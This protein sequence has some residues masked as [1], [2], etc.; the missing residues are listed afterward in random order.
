MT[1]DSAAL[2]AKLD[3]IEERLD[4]LTAR[5]TDDDVATLAAADA[6]LRTGRTRRFA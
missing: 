6:D 1:A 4:A 3:A 5:I 2:L